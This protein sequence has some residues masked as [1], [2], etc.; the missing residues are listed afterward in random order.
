MPTPRIQPGE[1]SEP[2][3][4]AA[5]ILARDTWRLALVCLLTG[6]GLALIAIAAWLN[7]NN[8]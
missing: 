3:A 7:W 1:G 2:A 8:P 6:C 4:L 5:R